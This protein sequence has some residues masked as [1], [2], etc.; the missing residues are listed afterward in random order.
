MARGGLSLG[1]FIYLIIG[2]VLAANRGY[3]SG[4]HDLST[5]VSALLAILLWPL[6]LFGVDL[7]ITLDM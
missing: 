6:L 3:L 7:H 1:G 4:L 2:L 5:I